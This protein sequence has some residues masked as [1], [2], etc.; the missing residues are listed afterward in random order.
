MW[1]WLISS[2]WLN[3][4]GL[5]FNFGGALVLSYGA[6]TSPMRAKEL[7]ATKWGGNEA[8]LKD[9]LQTSRNSKVGLILLAVGFLM[10]LPANLP[11]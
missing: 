2:G 3:F 10:Q 11:R 1:H 7:A 4:F 6:I 8:A 5:A 9:R